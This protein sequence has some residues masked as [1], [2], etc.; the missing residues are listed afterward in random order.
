MYFP[1]L[2]GKRHELSALRK[3][4]SLLSPQK[5]WSIIEPVKRNSNE[6]EVTI[7]TL[8]TSNFVPILV[9][10]PLEGELAGNSNITLSFQNKTLRFL[11]CIAFSHNNFSTAVQIAQ[12]LIRDGV[13]FATYFKDEPTSN[14]TA[15]TSLASVNAVF[16]TP[17]TSSNFLNSLPNLVKIQDCFRAMARNADYPTVPYNFSDAHLTYRNLPNAIGFGDF[18]IVGSVFSATGGPARA[19]ALHITYINSLFN[20]HM[21]IKHCVSTIDNGTT[22]NTSNKYLEALNEL[23]SFAHRTPDIDQSTIGFQEILSYHARQ[24][25]PNLGPIKE[26]S[27]MHHIETLNKFIRRS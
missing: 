17:S 27:I 13:N 26:C 12:Q 21:F 25:Y 6:L 18:Q 7:N 15:I 19:V 23:V 20:N 1:F 9:I 24:H 10:N 2:R 14:V 16:T 4:A 22:T 5:V 8:N 11:P 3:T